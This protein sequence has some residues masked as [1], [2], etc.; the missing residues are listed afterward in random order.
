M[1][2]LGVKLC[3]L[4]SYHQHTNTDYITNRTFCGACVFAKSSDFPFDAGMFVAKLRAL[5]HVLR[6]HARVILAV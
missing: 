5:L 2:R 4:D 3:F 6:E 1:S